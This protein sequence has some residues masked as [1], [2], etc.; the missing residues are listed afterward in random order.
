MWRYLTKKSQSA[1][2]GSGRQRPPRICR[3]TA[4]V[5]TTLQMTHGIGGESDN[6]NHEDGGKPRSANMW[7]RCL[8]HSTACRMHLQT[9]Q[10][11][12]CRRL[13]R[14]LRAL[15][16]IIHIYSHTDCVTKWQS[17]KIL[18]PGRRKHLGV[19]TILYQSQS[20]TLA[21]KIF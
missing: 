6:I 11:A 12:L 18:S 13:S 5:G 3:V 14:T 20:P 1:E 10:S 2:H 19:R 15:W 17:P 8:C 16:S 4:D 21:P 9:R 7:S